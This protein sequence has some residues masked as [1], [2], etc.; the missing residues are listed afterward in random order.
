MLTPRWFFDKLEDKTKRRK[1]VED[2]RH[3]NS[4]Q[5]TNQL[6]VPASVSEYTVHSSKPKETNTVNQAAYQQSTVVG[7][8]TLLRYQTCTSIHFNFI[9]KTQNNT[10][11]S[12]ANNHTH[13]SLPAVLPGE[14]G[15]TGSSLQTSCLTPSHNVLFRQEK[16]WLWMKRSSGKVH[17][18]RGN[19]CRVAKDIQW[20]SSI[21]QPP[22]NSWEKKGLLHFMSGVSQ[23]LLSTKTPLTFC[24]LRL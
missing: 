13:V 19:W 6:T 16:G 8:G 24:T 11:T 18:K 9:L 17:S 21:L 14:P 4:R 1:F 5:F 7:D 15:F 12:V 10:C 20:T 2:S 22:T 23:K 3:L